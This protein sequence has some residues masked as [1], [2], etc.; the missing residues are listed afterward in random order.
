MGLD[1]YLYRYENKE[2]TDTLETKYQEFSKS[3]WGDKSYESLSQEEKDQL[4]AADKRYAA[5]LGLD[6]WGYDKINK[7][8]IEFPSK[9]YPDHYFKIGYFR[10]SYNDGGINRILLNLGLSSLARI[11]NTNDDG[12]VISPDWTLA[13]IKVKEVIDQLKQK[14][15]LRCFDVSWNTFRN[16][17]DCK[18]TDESEALLT[19][20]EERNKNNDKDFSSYSNI[21]GIF[22]HSEPIKVYGILSGVKKALFTDQLLPCAYVVCDGP[23]EWY[24]QA[25]EIVQETIEYVLEQPDKD[26]Y[27]LHWSG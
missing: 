27:F 20:M 6:S 14:P 24:I 26:K 4:S 17:N 19:Y 2:L 3:N 16:P 10:S 9:K 11:F 22:N 8:Q 21:N 25:L 18:I 5:E 23:N 13:L 1:I 12:Y 15:N 7:E